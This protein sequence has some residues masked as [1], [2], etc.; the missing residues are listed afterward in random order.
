[1]ISLDEHII[2]HFITGKCSEE[3][4]QK[5]NEWLRENPGQ[6]EDLFAL[7]R[8][9]SS[10]QAR[11]MSAM[12]IEKALER[13]RR[14]TEEDDVKVKTPTIHLKLRRYMVAAVAVL[15]AGLAIFWFG[16]NFTAVQ[17]E[18]IT[19][20][21]SDS[22]VRK[23]VLPDGSLVW[24][25][26]N[27]T[28]CYPKSF[29]SSERRVK[30]IGEGYFEVAKN[31]KHP[32]VVESQA[33]NVKVIGTKFNFNNDSLANCSVVSLMEGAVEVSSNCSD[34]HLVL[35]PGQ[36]AHLDY[37]TGHITV[38]QMETKTDA[39]WRYHVITFN[40]STIK[41][42]ARKLESVYGVTITVSGRLDEGNTYSGRVLQKEN[43][44]EVFESLQYSLPIE[45][46]K[47]N[48]TTYLWD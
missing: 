42:I 20:H 39:S 14:R 48:Q 38:S 3:E 43:L 36:K 33:M 40:Q 11:G 37:H 44:E 41:E 9:Y 19:V 30:L 8:M 34:G 25:N 12:K 31:M 27:A 16:R 17:E 32:F 24:L 1:M 7:E 18:L 35:S 21:A 47:I 6:A 4:L 5:V 23:V 46:K 28:L 2:I 22:V 45:Y 29:A 10:L 26:K 15:I 13:V